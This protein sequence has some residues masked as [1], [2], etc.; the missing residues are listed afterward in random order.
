MSK[1]S[2]VVDGNV[3][4]SGE[5][6]GTMTTQSSPKPAAPVAPPVG[7]AAEA[8]VAPSILNVGFL[9]QGST[10]DN[11]KVLQKALVTLGYLSD[12]RGNRDG[13]FGAKT[14][15]AVLAFQRDRMSEFGADG[16]VGRR[17]RAALLSELNEHNG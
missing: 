17:T 5:F 7:S 16:K 15:D 14:H 13:V 2:L 8:A 4:L 10:G 9:K 1:F 6:N 3:V 11:V 12:K